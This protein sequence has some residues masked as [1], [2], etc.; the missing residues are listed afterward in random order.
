MIESYLDDEQPSPS[1]KR[2]QD[3][4]VPLETAIVLPLQSPRKPNEAHSSTKSPRKQ[5]TI[6]KSKSPRNIS[7]DDK[8]MNS[9]TKNLNCYQENV[10]TYEVT[11]D[12]PNIKSVDCDPEDW[13]FQKREK[14]KVSCFFFLHLTNF[15]M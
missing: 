14:A 5:G 11:S 12:L 2:R 1:K 10:N 7:E 9:P 4:S 3:S 13:V 8:N 6:R 15:I